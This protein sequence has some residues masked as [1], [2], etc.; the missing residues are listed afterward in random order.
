[1]SVFSFGLQKVGGVECVVISDVVAESP[2][3]DDAVLIDL[4]G[5]LGEASYCNYVGADA[6]EQAREEHPNKPVVGFW[7]TMFANKQITIG[8]TFKHVTSADGGTYLVTADGAFESRSLK[9][10]RPVRREDEE[11]LD[12]AVSLDVDADALQLPEPIVTAAERAAATERE[13]RSNM[14]VAAVAVAVTFATSTAVGV[15]NSEARERQQQAIKAQAAHVDKLQ[16]EMDRLLSSHLSE[17]PQTAQ[18]LEVVARLADERRPFTMKSQ[19]IAGKMSAELL[20]LAPGNLPQQVPTWFVGD[21]RLLQ[22]GRVRLTW[23][24]GK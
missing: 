14:L 16:T 1:M 9:H 22:N 10:G 2:P 12:G 4:E 19:E 17:R 3:R 20:P 24:V 18:R 6:F 7:Q 8:Q 11:L 21:A 13:S 15:W 5:R 23:E